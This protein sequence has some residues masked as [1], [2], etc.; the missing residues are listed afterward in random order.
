MAKYLY[1]QLLRFKEK[2]VQ[3]KLIFQNEIIFFILFM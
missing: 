1:E 2:K 3:K